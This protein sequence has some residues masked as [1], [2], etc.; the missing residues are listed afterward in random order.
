[1]SSLNLSSSLCIKIL[2]LWLFLPIHPA[3]VNFLALVRLH[4]DYCSI[5]FSA[6]DTV[7]LNYIHNMLA[8][9]AL[10]INSITSLS[11][12]NILSR[13]AIPGWSFFWYS[14]ERCGMGRNNP[15]SDASVP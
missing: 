4:F 13:L 15:R 5:F 11:Q 2:N 9:I 1:M 6:F 10:L 8:N 12:N 7:L 3:K 14:R